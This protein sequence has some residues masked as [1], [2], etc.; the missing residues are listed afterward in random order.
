MSKKIEK[1]KR[2]HPLW[3]IYK[4][5]LSIKEV[6]APVIIFFVINLKNEALW[7]KL[8]SIALIIYI[9]YRM[10]AIMFEWKNHT[11]LFTNK[12]IEVFEGRFIAKKRYVALNRIQSYQQ[13]T[14]FFHRLFHL[15]SLSIITGT[16]SDNAAIK[17]QM[18]SQR[19]AENIIEQLQRF[20]QETAFITNEDS[21]NLQIDKRKVHYRM[22]FQEIFLISLSSL[23]FLAIFPILLSIY[24]KIDEL[25]SLDTF[26]TKMYDFLTQSWLMIMIVSIIIIIISVCSGIIITYLRFGNYEIASDQQIIYISKGVLHKTNYTI[27]RDKING[28]RIEKS[29]PRRLFNI[30]KVQIISLGDLFDEVEMETDIL[31]P[32]IGEDRLKQLLPEIVP[33]FMREEDMNG[34]PKQALFMNL[35]QPSYTLVIVTFLIFFFWPEYWFIPVVLLIF[36]IT[37]RIVKTYQTKFVRTNKLIQL[38]TGALSTELFIT[39]REKID[40]LEIEQTWLEQRL[41]LATVSI[42]SRAKPIYVSRIEHIPQKSA[43]AYYYWFKEEASEHEKL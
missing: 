38:Q 20:K 4:L 28:L 24:F 25:F 10:I 30:C 19:E 39:R 29:F 7:V 16:S 21:K 5:G 37:V 31:F 41:R 43:F 6:I 32:F 27:P 35:I 26:T 2:Q 23:Y 33:Q 34:L 15:T 36:T 9:L 22:S 14:S 13:H 12:N 17:L 1:R 42:T 3:I 18:I 40:E 8:G 11:Y